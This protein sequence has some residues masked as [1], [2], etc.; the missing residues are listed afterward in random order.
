MGTIS[1]IYM[2]VAI[3]SCFISVISYFNTRNKEYIDRID[4]W[5]KNFNDKLNKLLNYSGSNSVLTFKYDLS[6]CLMLDFGDKTDAEKYNNYIKLNVINKDELK[7]CY[8]EAVAVINL[9]ANNK[10]NNQIIV[11]DLINKLYR[12]IDDHYSNIL[13]LNDK[14]ELFFVNKITEKDI[15]CFIDE[16]FI[17]IK[18]V[19]LIHS[20][21]E[22][23]KN[24][25]MNLIQ[26]TLISNKN[27]MWFSTKKL[28][29]CMILYLNTFDEYKYYNKRTMD[30]LS[31]DFCIWLGSVDKEI[32]LCKKE[33]FENLKIG[34]KEFQDKL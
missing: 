20:I 3:I 31:Q 22:K 4:I 27:I 24:N 32:D 2:S 17:N 15:I 28:L 10:N 30:G 19:I 13:E 11:E 34:K 5:S 8:Q 1:T 26:I 12:V 29:K 6:N 23:L 7:S 25:I 9:T 21:V 14:R 18:E 16:I 33:V